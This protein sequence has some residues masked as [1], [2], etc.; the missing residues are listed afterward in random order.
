V[1]LTNI[2]KLKPSY[3]IVCGSV[4]KA[5][6]LFFKASWLDFGSVQL[7]S[8]NRGLYFRRKVGHG[9]NL[10]YHTHLVLRSEK[11]ATLLLRP[12]VTLY[13]A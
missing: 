10:T 13:G 7:R 3:K 5:I 6:F 1:Y 12:H 11:H 4:R 8:K 9:V 2:V